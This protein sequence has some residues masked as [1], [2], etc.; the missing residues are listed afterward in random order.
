MARQVTAILGASGLGS[1]TAPGRAQLEQARLGRL[2]SWIVGSEGLSFE[3][4]LLEDAPASPPH[5]AAPA[6]TRA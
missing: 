6:E 2:C 4:A 3:P 5:R 1:L